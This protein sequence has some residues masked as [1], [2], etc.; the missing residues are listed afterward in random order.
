MQSF[1]FLI[2]DIFL[3]VKSIGVGV[4]YD[5]AGH[6]FEIDSPFA[7]KIYGLVVLLNIFLITGVGIWKTFITPKKKDLL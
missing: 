4:V 3:I 2:L 7:L 5:F 1:I 6:Y